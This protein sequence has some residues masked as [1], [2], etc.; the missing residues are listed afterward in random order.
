MSAIASK[1]PEGVQEISQGSSASNASATTPGN[2]TE[3]TPLTAKPR[4][5]ANLMPGP[6][7]NVLSLFSI[8]D[9]PP[10]LH[11][12][13]SS[14]LH[15]PSSPRIDALQ[16]AIERLPQVALPLTHRFTPGMYIRTIQMPKGAIVVSKIHRTQHPFVITK[17][18]CAVWDAQNGVHELC[19]GHIGITMPGTRR[20]LY[21]HEDTEWTT[22]H[23]SDKTTPEAVEAD[24]IEPHDF[25]RKQAL[26]DFGLAIG[27]RTRPA[28]CERA[29]ARANPETINPQ[30]S[31]HH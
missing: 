19:A 31:T 26:K 16:A 17:G 22:F 14:T 18:R 5:S 7:Q 21:I 11:N 24:I 12:A 8:L 27:E 20:I 3:S 6:F 1:C 28:C 23:A 30:L 13:P 25:D 2:R 9:F 29:P 15:P 10:S 4:G